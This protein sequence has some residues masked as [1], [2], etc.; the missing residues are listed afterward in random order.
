[1]SSTRLQLLRLSEVTA[2]TWVSPLSCVALQL[3]KCKGCV[4]QEA[5]RSSSSS[6]GAGTEHRSENLPDH[7]ASKTKALKLAEPKRQLIAMQLLRAPVNT[8]R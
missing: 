6:S 4:R 1:M 3:F 5:N 8:S 7:I 2:S